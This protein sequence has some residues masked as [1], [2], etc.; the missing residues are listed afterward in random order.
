MQNLGSPRRVEGEIGERLI[1]AL[2][3]LLAL[4]PDSDDDDLENLDDQVREM[5][6]GNLEVTFHKSASVGI[7]VSAGLDPAT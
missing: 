2:E 7:G 4:P 1:H 6:G 5:D 3:T